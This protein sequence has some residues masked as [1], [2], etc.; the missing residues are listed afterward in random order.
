MAGRL[1]CRMAYSMSL[2][3]LSSSFIVFARWRILGEQQPLEVGTAIV[4]PLELF[5]QPS[6]TG[7]PRPGREIVKCDRQLAQ[8]LRGRLQAVE[9][10]LPARLAAL[11]VVT[12]G[13]PES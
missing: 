6:G 13:S 8:S 10:A 2:E 3:C 11:D 1:V 4:G 7:R 9:D 5:E 12:G